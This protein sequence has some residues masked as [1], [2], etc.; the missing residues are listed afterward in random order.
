MIVTVG[1]LAPQKDLATM[2]ESVALLN[3]GTL[4]IVGEGP[5][6]SELRRFADERGVSSRLRFVGFRDRAHDYIASAD[7]FC[8]SSVWEAVYLAAQE[9][10]S[11]CV[12]VVATDTGGIRELI[13]DGS[14]GLLVSPG[15]PAT[16]ARSIA[17]VLAD[18]AA[19][20][21]RADLAKSLYEGRFGLESML[22]ELER[23]YREL[24]VA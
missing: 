7:V 8:L 21:R 11:L 13:E 24:A 16:L 3:E 5:L 22:G 14:T 19:A 10:V 9:A 20:K 23:V 6:E 2:I 1:R 17:A 4:A 12:P 18:P 15:D